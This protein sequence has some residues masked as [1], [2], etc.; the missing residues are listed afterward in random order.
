MGPLTGRI[1]VYAR[2]DAHG[3]RLREA[4]AREGHDVHLLTGAIEDA[5]LVDLDPDVVIVAVF[6]DSPG[7]ALIEQSHRLV[8]HV[9]CIAISERDASGPLLESLRHGADQC[10]IEPVTDEAVRLLVGRGLE[11]AL[12]SRSASQP[13]HAGEPVLAP[14]DRIVGTHPAMQRL[15]ARLRQAAQSRATVLIHG[16]TGTGKELIGEAIHRYSKR[17]AGPFVRLNCAAL[18]EGVLESELFGHE[19]GSFTGA[20]SRRVG[21]FE[22]AHG[23]TLFLD[24][25][26]ELPPSIQIKLLRVLQEREI[27]RVGGNETIR[28]DVR[29]VAATNRALAALVE[30]GR[31]REDLYYRLKV[32]VLEVPPLR[33]RPSD[34]PVLADHF[35]RKHADDN[36]KHIRGFTRAA[37]DALLS[38]PWPGNVRELEHAVE[39]AVVFCERDL[40]GVDDLPFSPPEE[41]VEPLSLMIPGITMAEV[42]R[43]VILKTLEAVGN[44]PSRA[45]SILGI[46]RRTIQYRLAEWG[47][48]R[49]DGKRD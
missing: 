39:Q 3:D 1:A 21:R 18:A 33:A 40:I 32:V 31:F 5:A 4:L 49:G 6:A 7:F 20:A 24:E 9:P 16:E 25:V 27:E 35:L 38:H 17:A 11:R 15:F 37:L 47:Q 43:Y 34:V 29:I 46:S 26:S 30:D 48:G 8:P 22:Q 41:R 45:A 10:L 44:S 42:E 23:G 12:A 13:V 2:D 14:L 19:K 28:V 36:D